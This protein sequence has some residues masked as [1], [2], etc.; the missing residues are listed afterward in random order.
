MAFLVKSTQIRHLWSQIQAFLF[1]RKILQLDK[2]EGGDFKY[3]N[4]VFKCQSK[5]R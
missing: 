3:D 4:I 2:F 1:S 5:N